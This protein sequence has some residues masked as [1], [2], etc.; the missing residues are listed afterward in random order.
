M[1]TYRSEEE[2]VAGEPRVT[3]R[4]KS[5]GLPLRVDECLVGGFS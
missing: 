2:V 4:C 3:H 5:E 1:S